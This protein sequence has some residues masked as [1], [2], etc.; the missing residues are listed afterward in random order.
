MMIFFSERTD[1][2]LYNKV[3]NSGT[4]E[5][6]PQ[7]LNRKDW[8][9]PFTC[10]IALLVLATHLYVTDFVVFKPWGTT[11]RFYQMVSFHVFLATMILF[12]H[13]KAM[14]TD[15]GSV[16]R[17]AQPVNHSQSS[18][19]NMG[20][21]QCRA[22]KPASS[23]HCK[24][25]KRCIVRMDHHCPW[26]N[27]CV[28]IN[29]NKLYVQFCVYVTMHC[30]YCLTIIVLRYRSCDE[31]ARRS[32]NSKLFNY[33]C[34]DYTTCE[35]VMVY[36]VVL[37]AIFFAGFTT[38]I[39]IDQWTL[40]M[41]NRTMIDRKKKLKGRILSFQKKMQIFFGGKG[42]FELHWILPTLPKYD[43]S[44]YSEFA[45]YDAMQFRGRTLNLNRR[46]SQLSITNQE[47]KKHSVV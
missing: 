26:L 11:A 3:A 32:R 13:T 17:K 23:H 2:S 37:T 19:G 42:T 9:G 38:F 18:N 5:E 30:L 36:V 15:P 4:K 14:I 12:T 10:S 6:S 45:E 1:S 25:C 34:P 16:P 8:V 35:L 7:W 44:S 22:F 21:Q 27:N 24:I 41:E 43:P 31:S 47:D 20:C 33:T 28:G 46:A 39:A 29:N 40:L